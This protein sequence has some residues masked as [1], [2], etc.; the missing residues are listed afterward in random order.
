M[1]SLTLAVITCSILLSV[2]AWR[3]NDFLPDLNS[4]LVKHSRPELKNSKGV[5]QLASALLKDLD[6]ADEILDNSPLP[7]AE[8]FYTTAQQSTKTHPKF[9]KIWNKLQQNDYNYIGY[10]ENDSEALA[11]ILRLKSANLKPANLKSTAAEPP[12]HLK[13]G[14][15]Q[16]KV[17]SV[18]EDGKLGPTALIKGLNKRLGLNMHIDDEL[19]RFAIGLDTTGFDA[20]AELEKLCPDGYECSLSSYA[21]SGYSSV[22][23]A[24]DYFA[25]KEYNKENKKV[26]VSFAPPDEF[27]L[28]CIN[29]TKL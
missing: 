17:E 28:V 14:K 26:G 7:I 16:L 13:H 22:E 9:H 21:G 8:A 19:S 24:V 1:K 15:A 23:K 12:K 4:R 6:R 11:L 29:K 2:S 25:T 5:N 27:R 3:V 20:K 10:A 18:K